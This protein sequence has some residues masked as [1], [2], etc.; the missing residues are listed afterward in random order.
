MNARQWIMGD[1]YTI[2]DIAIWPWVLNLVGFYGAADL[3]SFGD[4]S[5]LPPVMKAFE[6]RPAV[7]R[8]LQILARD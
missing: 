8:G 3:I 6:A 2:A 5:H 7:A 4:F 1:D